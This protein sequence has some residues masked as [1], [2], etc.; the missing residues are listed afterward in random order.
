MEEKFFTRLGD[1]NWQDFG[2]CEYYDCQLK[3]SFGNYEK[4][5]LIPCIIINYDEG[6]MTFCDS[7]DKALEDF[8][9]TLCLDN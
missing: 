9:V 7:D 8:P 6:L 4:G 3:R 2:V 5:D 1:I